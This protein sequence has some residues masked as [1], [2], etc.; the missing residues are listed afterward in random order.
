MSADVRCIVCAEPMPGGGRVRSCSKCG[1]LLMKN[2]VPL[3][4]KRNGTT[5]TTTDI[6]DGKAHKKKDNDPRA[7][8]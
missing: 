4:I 6:R 1:T 7:A 8:S 3:W 2:P 5:I